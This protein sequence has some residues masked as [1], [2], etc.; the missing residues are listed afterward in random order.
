M[1]VLTK[2]R[3]GSVLLRAVLASGRQIHLYSEVLEI[4]ILVE[5]GFIGKIRLPLTVKNRT[6]PKDSTGT[7]STETW[8]R[9]LTRVHVIVILEERYI[10]KF[11]STF[12]ANIGGYEH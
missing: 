5:V 6:K 3:T 2:K 10:G 1:R 8:S 7:G 12:R 9:R 4:G 11:R